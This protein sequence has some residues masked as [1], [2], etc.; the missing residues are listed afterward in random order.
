MIVV[1]VAA[2][3][4]SFQFL[5]LRSTVRL[6]LYSSDGRCCCQSSQSE[7]SS[8]S[9]ESLSSTQPDT[10]VCSSNTTNHNQG[11]VFGDQDTAMAQ[12]QGVKSFTQKPRVSVMLYVSFVASGKLADWC[13]TALSA[14]TGYIVP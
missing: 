11:W 5:C 10:V 14:Q 3:L 9:S 2:A 7:S 12:W 8:H 6:V 4:F 1:V 13:L